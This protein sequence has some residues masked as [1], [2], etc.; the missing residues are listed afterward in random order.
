VLEQA[1]QTQAKLITELN[2]A[3]SRIKTLE[4]II[5]IC[6]NCK[7]IR[8]DEGFWQQVEVYISQ[9]S[10]ADFSHGICPDCMQTLYPEFS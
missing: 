7:K 8:D 2:G 1:N 4:G 10:G 6:A 3:I 5:P 9:H